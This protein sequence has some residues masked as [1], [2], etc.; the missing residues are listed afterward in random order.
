MRPVARCSL[1]K[2]CADVGGCGVQGP[3]CHKHPSGIQLPKE[4][5][6]TIVIVNGGR[7]VEDCPL[8]YLLLHSASADSSLECQ[9]TSTAPVAEKSFLH[10]HNLLI[11]LLLCCR[12]RNCLAVIFSFHQHLLPVVVSVEVQAISD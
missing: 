7:E 9:N 2:R 8:H 6:E 1:G 3:A 5:G 4:R 11:V 12:H 10:I